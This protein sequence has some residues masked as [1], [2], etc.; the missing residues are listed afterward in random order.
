M[1][2]MRHLEPDCRA[3]ITRF[4]YNMCNGLLAYPLLENLDYRRVL[5]DEPSSAEQAIAIFLN[6][7]TMDAAGK[8]LDAQKAEFRA[9]QYIRGYCDPGYRI[10]PPLS[11]WELERQ[12]YNRRSSGP[13][14]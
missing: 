1:G 10:E 5:W 13:M 7:L 3:V 2:R 8:V 14:P 12:P 9:G 4:V 6:A 11:S